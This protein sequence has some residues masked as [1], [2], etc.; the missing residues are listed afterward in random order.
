MKSSFEWIIAA[1]IL[2]ALAAL[3]FGI[4][5]VLNVISTVFALG[6]GLVVALILAVVIATLGWIG[7]RDAIDEIKMDRKQGLPWLWRCVG[8]IGIA[9]I[10][11]D[12]IVGAWNA[13]QEHVLFSIAVKEI[14]FAGVPVLLVLGSYPVKWAEALLAKGRRRRADRSRLNT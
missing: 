14:P 8:W 13:Y 5:A 1:L 6:F 7:I 9:G 10:L 12:G 2:G 4:D 11:A 3:V